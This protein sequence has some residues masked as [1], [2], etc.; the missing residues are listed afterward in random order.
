MSHR[1]RPFPLTLSFVGALLL[2]PALRAQP[3]FWRL[4]IQDAPPLDLPPL[5]ANVGTADSVFVTRAAL[6]PPAR[7]RLAAGLGFE[8]VHA[9]DAAATGPAILTRSWTG[10]IPGDPRLRVEA[11]GAA[12]TALGRGAGV[13]E[14]LAAARDE[15]L[16]AAVLVGV[17]PDAV[18]P[19]GWTRCGEAGAA[20]VVWTRAVHVQGVRV[21][22]SCRRITFMD[23]GPA[24]DP[25]TN[26]LLR[27]YYAG[28]GLKLG[29]FPRRL[30]GIATAPDGALYWSWT[31]RIVKTSPEGE[32]LAA[33]EVQG[34]HGDLTWRD[35]RV[36]VAVNRGRF[37]D[38][39]A[40]HDSWACVLDADTLEE[41]GR[42]ELPEV[43]YGAAG[44]CWARDR[45]VVVG[46]LPVEL[47]HADDAANEV[48]EYD[49]D[50]RWLATVRLPGGWTRHGI[51][52][53]EFAFGRFFFG[54]D[55]D[56]PCVLV[57]SPD[58]RHVERLDGEGA[59]AAAGVTRAPGGMLLL[60][61]ERAGADG[62]R[63]GLMVV[64]PRM[65]WYRN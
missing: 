31:D 9:V 40:A 46:G 56:P 2:V 58:L 59:R 57:A 11:D 20:P 16:P 36:V 51:Q 62:H 22:G 26:A 54:C 53:A 60:G 34:H 63:G 17:H 24:R 61:V 19:A 30:Q 41:A 6:S 35:G 32:V 3:T 48:H 33:A 15:P 64:P 42:H 43:R 27:R 65:L 23:G 49:A 50:F 37:H 25:Q 12:I 14:S 10:R 29:P 4:A 47:E 5:P 8:H 1:P 13:A 45:Y 38:P 28:I 7:I 18:P 21:E 55:G 39:E 44:I 52:T